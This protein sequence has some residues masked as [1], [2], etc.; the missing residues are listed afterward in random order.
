M[1]LRSG[2]LLLLLLLPEGGGGSSALECLFYQDMII[3]LDLKS[4]REASLPD[5]LQSVLTLWSSTPLASKQRVF[6]TPPCHFS[7]SLLCTDAAAAAAT[8]TSDDKH[9]WQTIHI[10]YM[11]S[12]QVYRPSGP[13]LLA[14]GPSGLLT[15]SFAPFGRS[16][17]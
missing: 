5:R 3:F 8:T 11:T 13:R 4:E 17:R 7:P 1:D 16:V 12:L 6:F 10:Y 9:T 14:G 15:S 2:V